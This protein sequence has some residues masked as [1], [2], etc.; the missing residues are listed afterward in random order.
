[1]ILGFSS[2]CLYK[3]HDRLAKETFDIFKSTGANAI[4]VMCASVDNI[5]RLLEISLSDLEGFEYVTLHAPNLGIV[6]QEDLE[7]ALENFEE[8]Q[9]KFNF[10]HVVLHPDGIENWEVFSKFNIPWAIENMDQRKESG[11]DVADMKKVF[12]ELN[13]KMV[14]DLN[15]CYV[16]DSSME[17]A[18]DFVEEFKDR[19][20]E[21]H[22][23]GF[24][25]LHEPLFKTKQKEILGA[26][27]DKNIPIIIESG[28]ETVDDVKKEYE[29]VK[30]H[31]K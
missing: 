3:T 19:I 25:T 15:H 17:L 5:S 13:A 22:L 10:K 18:Q 11:K 27:Y 16:N 23:S 24:E 7:S 2:G 1:M 14:L 4:E 21:I 30:N 20:V 31:L 29:Y 12:E 28:C 8:A 26:I 9:G 6:S